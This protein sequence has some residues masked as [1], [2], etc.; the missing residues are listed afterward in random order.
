MTIEASTLTTRDRARGTDTNDESLGFVRVIS[1]I[2]AREAAT[3]LAGHAAALPYL[4]MAHAE[5]TDFGQRRS[6]A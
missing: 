2:A 4:G 6:N 5:L 3:D 1:P